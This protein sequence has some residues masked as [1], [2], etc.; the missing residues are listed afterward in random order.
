MSSPTLTPAERAALTRQSYAQMRDRMLRVRRLSG[1][2][3]SKA[4]AVQPVTGTTPERPP[5][6][7][8]GGC[9]CH[10]PLSETP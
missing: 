9:P 7:E 3:G 1:V 10:E 2:A 4:A 8:S 6:A 5:H